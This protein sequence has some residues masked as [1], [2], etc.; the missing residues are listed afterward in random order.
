MSFE[1][2]FIKEPENPMGNKVYFMGVG[3]IAMGN[4]AMMFHEMGYDVVGSDSALYP[5]M[6]NYLAKAAIRVHMPYSETNISSEKMNMVVVGN[7]IRATNPEAIWLMDNGG[8]IPYV[9][10][11]EAV[12][13]FVIRDRKSL[14]VAGTHGKSTTA[15]LLGWLLEKLG[16]D[17]TVF[18]GAIMRTWD[19]GYRLGNGDF[20]VLEGDEY[21]TAFFDKIPKFLHYSPFGTIITGI[22]FDHADIY[23]NIDEIR[24]AFEKF[25]AL[26]PPNGIMVVFDKEPHRYRLAEICRGIVVTYGFGNDA[27]WKLLEYSP[28]GG[29]SKCVIQ[30]KGCGD[31]K[32]ILN[33]MGKHNALNTLGVIALLDALGI[34]Q[35]CGF[36]RLQ[37]AL[38]SF[39]G[40]KRRQEVLFTNGQYVVIDDF[41]H[42]PTAV[43][44]TI[45]AVRY[46]FPHQRIIAIFEPRTNTSKRKIFQEDYVRALSGADNVLLKTPPGYTDL[47]S[48]D[49]IDLNKLAA[50]LDA[51]GIPSHCFFDTDDLFQQIVKSKGEKVL[52][53][54]SNGAMDKLPWRV[55]DYFKSLKD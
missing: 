33:T 35:K 41:A 23:R 18:I 16:E 13:K 7:V 51:R 12:K 25:V 6:S 37:E 52:L 50:D 31:F 47:P 54:M 48:Q 8:K 1:R 3:G 27:D 32:I 11:A 39:P 55:A 5:P 17:P 28:R 49:R 4:L 20:A 40:L 38:S 30:K 26:I 22:E 44:E 2:N 21:D 53:F 10:M 14:V 43:R 42:H 36:S 15:A 9:S 34:L 19:R 29:K 45:S 46:H 24:S